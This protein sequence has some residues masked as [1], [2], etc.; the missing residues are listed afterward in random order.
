MDI[1]DVQDV[2]TGPSAAAV[3]GI[4][5]VNEV[6]EVAV[7]GTADVP[8]DTANALQQTHTEALHCLH[9]S[10]PAGAGTEALGTP[11]LAIEAE[12]DGR[13]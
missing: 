5:L 11:L 3:V 6:L 7:G 12:T 13:H 1:L 2:K 9:D 8:A 10:E 4:S